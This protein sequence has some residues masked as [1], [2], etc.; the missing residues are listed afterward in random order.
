[1]KHKR[2]LA[3]FVAIEILLLIPFIS[4][5]FTKE[6]NW[7]LFD[8]IVAAVL[9]GSAGIILELIIR[10]VRTFNKRLLAII[11]LAIFFLLIWLE[12]A[13]GIFGSP[14]AGS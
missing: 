7:S 14:I 12:L 13:V 6:V 3:I 11:A 9:L 1:M 8:Y 5:F 10:N 2:F 4:S